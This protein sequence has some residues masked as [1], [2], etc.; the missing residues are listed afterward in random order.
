MSQTKSYVRLLTAPPGRPD[1]RFIVGVVLENQ[2]RPLAGLTVD[3]D[4]VVV[5]LCVEQFFPSEQLL[6]KAGA[7][8]I[9]I[10]PFG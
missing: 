8:G 1:N 3:G 10:F 9:I 4:K 6:I 5:L 7:A 2:H